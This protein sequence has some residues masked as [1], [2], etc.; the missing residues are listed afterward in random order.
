[1][2]F[3]RKISEEIQYQLNLGS[4]ISVGK[5]FCSVFLVL[6]QR[7]W[8]SAEALSRTHDCLWGNS[9]YDPKG[10]CARGSAA[11]LAAQ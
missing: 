1:M 4:S 2:T 11:S 7:E 8:I 3:H 5:D 10:F 6:L 9:S